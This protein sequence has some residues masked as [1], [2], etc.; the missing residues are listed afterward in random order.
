VQ[1]HNTTT[2]LKVSYQVINDL[3]TWFSFA[4]SNIRGD[5]RWSPEYFF[6]S[7][8]TVNLGVSFGF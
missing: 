8:N 2:G 5:A 3:Y 6:G 7:K 4:S 1:W